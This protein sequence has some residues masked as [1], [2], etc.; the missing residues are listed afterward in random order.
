MD[1]AK[2]LKTVR[3]ERGLKQKDLAE[4]LHIDNRQISKLETSYVEPN[5]QLLARI[6]DA[7]QCSVDYLLGRESDE[8][9]IIINNDNQVA[10]KS[11]LE[12]I[13]EQLPYQYQMQLLGFAQALLRNCAS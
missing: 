4:L 11:E 5:L 10:K 12:K 8:G 13:N 9:Y 2:Q 6:A 3:I 1:F 7:L